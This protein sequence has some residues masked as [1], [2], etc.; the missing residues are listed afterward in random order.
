MAGKLEDKHGWD[1]IIA[2]YDLVEN[3]FYESDEKK[4]TPSTESPTTLTDHCI[5]EIRIFLDEIENSP[6]ANNTPLIY[7][8]AIINNYYWNVIVDHFVLLNLF[9]KNVNYTSHLFTQWVNVFPK[10]YE[11]VLNIISQN[12]MMDRCGE[13]SVYVLQELPHYEKII[14]SVIAHNCIT[15]FVNATYRMD[16]EFTIEKFYDKYCA[17]YPDAK[18]GVL[19]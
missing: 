3:S 19:L 10:D 17:N 13:A 7:Y 14:E 4:N 6:N 8:I 2:L 15:E 9:V 16:K 12:P 18:L 1:L 11:K 5:K